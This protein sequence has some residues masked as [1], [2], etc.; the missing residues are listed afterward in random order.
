MR[1]PCG[2][3]NL[4]HPQA[5]RCFRI[6]SRGP[7]AK[8]LIFTFDFN[9]RPSIDGIS[10]NGMCRCSRKNCE[11]NELDN[12]IFCDRT[13]GL[14]RYKNGCH[15]MYTQGPCFRGSW[16]VPRREGKQEIFSDRNAERVGLCEC[17]PGYT[18]SF[19]SIGDKNMTVCLSPTVL[20]ADYMNKNYEISQS[21]NTK[22]WVSMMC[23]TNVMLI[24][25]FVYNKC[26]YN[27]L[28]SFSQKKFLGNLWVRCDCKYVILK[29]HENQMNRIVI[30]QYQYL[31]AMDSN[32]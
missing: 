24:F 2:R 27:Y 16:L 20:L 13:K 6:G 25:K 3:G 12:V 14:I 4:Y 19:R 9:T 21:T 28:F 1:Q 30:K 5:K 8:N 31:Y 32:H 10:Y 17:I 26:V 7:C 18:K 11:E 15:K 22:W 29:L 23:S